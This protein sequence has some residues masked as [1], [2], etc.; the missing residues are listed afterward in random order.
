M[1]N[2][3]QIS[4]N[5]SVFLEASFQMFLGLLEDTPATLF[6][7]HFHRSYYVFFI[8]IAFFFCSL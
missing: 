8:S 7:L 3:T 6:I 4:K 2:I 1:Y 5:S